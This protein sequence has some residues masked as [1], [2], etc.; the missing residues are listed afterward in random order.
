MAF[1]AVAST[2]F[3]YASGVRAA[4]L[5]G[6]RLA[7]FVGLFEVLF[8][9]LVSWVLLDEVP[10][11]V[12]AVGGALIVAGVVAVRAGEGADDEAVAPAPDSPIVDVG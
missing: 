6:A 4:K 11:A 3:A 1:V 7:S 12:Q 2:A 9:V 10:T 8:A 5:L